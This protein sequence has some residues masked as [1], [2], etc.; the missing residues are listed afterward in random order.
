MIDRSH[1]FSINQSINLCVGDSCACRTSSR[2]SRPDLVCMP[3]DMASYDD[4][5]NSF[6]FMYTSIS[7]NQS[8]NQSILK[9]VKRVYVERKISCSRWRPVVAVG[10]GLSVEPD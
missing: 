4:L 3:N 1:D 2:P 9:R 10:I 6:M 5:S 7:I 8:I